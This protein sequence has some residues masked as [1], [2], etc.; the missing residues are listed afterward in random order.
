M[1]A[2][3]LASLQFGLITVC[4]FLSGPSLTPARSDHLPDKHARVPRFVAR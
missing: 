3:G 2:L 1:D 4:H